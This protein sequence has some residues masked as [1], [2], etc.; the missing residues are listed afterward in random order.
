MRGGH[1]SIV[2]LWWVRREESDHLGMQW[3]FI[4]KKALTNRHTEKCDRSSLHLII[5]IDIGLGDC[6]AAMTS[7]T[8]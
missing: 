1:E 5:H 2:P 8:G 6:D 7:Q 4:A 3:I